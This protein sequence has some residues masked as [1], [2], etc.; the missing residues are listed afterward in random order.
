MAKRFFWL[1]TILL[2][3]VFILWIFT[4]SGKVSEADVL[5]EKDF[6][7]N[8]RIYAIPL[9][10]SLNFAG[11]AVPLDRYYVKEQ[12]DRELLINSY[13]QSQTIQFFKRANRWFPVFEPILKQ[14]NIPDDFKYLALIESGLMNAVS[15]AGATGFWQILEG[16]GKDL[17]LEINEFVD[18]RYN[19]E[20]ATVAACKYLLKSKEEYGSWTLAAAAYNMGNRGI[21]RQIERQKVQ[22][23]YDL[24]LN[25][26]TSRYVFRI[27]A[28]KVIFENPQ[29]AGF[30]YRE[31]DLYPPLDYKTISVDSTIS[32]LVDF[33]QQNNT[34]YRELRL[35]NPWLRQYELPN[36]KG[37]AYE[38]K[39]PL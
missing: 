12:F 31:T 11:E 37:K 33:A 2:S 36:K 28:M 24:H 3:S 35:L 13:W 5:Y 4:Y 1:A 18:E 7:D 19:V 6:L 23:Y 8:Y 39:V 30:Y 34:T 14:Y 15:P 10:E 16:T 27:L 38:I 17:G 29:K 9:P 26:E 22:S 21:Q 32:C 20:K 25:E